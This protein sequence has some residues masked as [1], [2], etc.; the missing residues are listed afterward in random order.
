MAFVVET[1]FGKGKRDDEGLRHTGG[2]P[3][4]RWSVAATEAA[5]LSRSGSLPKAARIEQNEPCLNLSHSV[6]PSF[7]YVSSPLSLF[8]VKKPKRK[9][10]SFTS[11]YSFL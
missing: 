2:L 5:T 9:K 3:K 10:G 7:S 4:Q 8:L 1:R 6:T 11:G